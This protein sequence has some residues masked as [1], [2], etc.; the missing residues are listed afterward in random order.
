MN[1]S[2]RDKRSTF[3]TLV[4]STTAFVSVGSGSL[5]SAQNAGG[6]AA[7]D[8]NAT[9]DEV[10]VTARRVDERLQDV[11]I[12]MTVFNQEQLDNRNIS[13]GRDLA[14]YTPSLSVTT[15]SATTMSA[16]C[17]A[18]SPRCRGRQHR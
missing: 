1:N 7:P 4:V 5:A 13:D 9:F 17:S 6:Q 3:R 16:F 11:P 2:K 10:I 14:L 8:R 18:V 15:R 12:S